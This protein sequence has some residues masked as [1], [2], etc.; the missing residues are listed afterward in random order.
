[1]SNFALSTLRSRKVNAAIKARE[2][3]AK[4]GPGIKG[5]LQKA[6]RYAGFLWRQLIDF[7]N[8]DFSSIWDMMFET[9][10][11][12]KEFDWNATDKELQTQI[13]KN[14]QRIVVAAAETLGE[15][16]PYGMFRLGNFFI[17]RL[18]GKFSRKGRAAQQG[19]KVPV[20]S[21]RIGLALAEESADEL[22][23]SMRS[24]ISRTGRA[25][26]NNMFINS[27]LTARKNEWLGLRS[28]TESRIDGSIAARIDRKIESLPKFWQEPV[29]EFLESFE[30]SLQ[31]VGYVV[32]FEIDDHMAALRAAREEQQPEKAIEVVPAKGAEPLTFTGPQDEVQQAITTTLAT[33]ERYEQS[34]LG[35]PG[36]WPLKPGA[37]RP[38]L[39]ITFRNEKRVT[40]ARLT[41]PHYDG[42]RSP[43]IPSYETGPWQGEWILKDGSYLRCYAATKAEAIRVIRSLSKYVPAIYKDGKPRARNIERTIKRQKVEPRV[44]EFYAEGPAAYPTWK[45]YFRFDA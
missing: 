32:S 9:Y 41:I 8:I 31:E 17:G 38:Q 14:N 37:S 11:E 7:F 13:E 15:L 43:S 5:V 20:L 22:R 42:P 16:L 19:I 12:I 40:S 35:I 24:F 25:Q 10:M 23:S 36:E 28:I 33:Y 4:V 6:L 39:V 3:L 2:A 29:E 27:V 34:G 45:A 26:I 30:D 18:I 21:A 1:M 44:A